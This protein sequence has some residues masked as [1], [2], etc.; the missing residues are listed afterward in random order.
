M[1]KRFFI[2]LL[3]FVTAC[4]LLAGCSGAS[5]GSSSGDQGSYTGS[6]EEYTASVEDDGSAYIEYLGATVEIESGEFINEDDG[7]GDFLCLSMTYTNDLG[8][9]ESEMDDEYEMDSPEASF[10]FQALQDGKTIYPRSYGETETIEEDAFYERIEQGQTVFCELYFPV[11]GKK[12]VTVQ[13]LNPDGEDTV[14]AEI[15]YDPASEF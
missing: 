4:M 12:P 15:V 2:L 11:D 10:V 14:M 5:D 6:G 1:Y 3:S 9:P 7:E 8:S 13:V